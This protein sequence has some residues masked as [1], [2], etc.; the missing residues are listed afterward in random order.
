MRR[1]ALIPC[2]ALVVGCGDTTSTTD[3][4]PA[5][6]QARPP[7]DLGASPDLATAAD[8]T[9]AADLLPEADLG[10]GPDLTPLPDLAVPPDL[11]VADDLT[12]PSDLA[13]PLDLATPADF[14][15]PPDFAIPPDFATPPDLAIP[16][17]L[18][19]PAD[20]TP[21]RDLVPPPDLSPSCS[22]QIK[23]GRETDVDCGGPTC[24]RCGDGQACAAGT[25]CGS[26][27]CTANKCAGTTLLLLHFDGTNN[28]QTFVDSSG[29]RRPVTVKGD[30]KTST[31]DSKFGGAS[32]LFDGNGDFLTVPDSTDW[33]LGT[34][35]FTIEFWMRSN[36]NVQSARMHTF[37]FGNGS[38]T[39]IDFDYNDKDAPLNGWGYWVYWNSGGANRVTTN[40]VYTDD[41]WHH[42]VLVRAN[43]VFVTFVDGK[44]LGRVNYAAAVNLAGPNLGKVIG[45]YAGGT[46]YFYKGY[47]DELRILKGV[48]AWTQNFTPPSQAY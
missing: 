9:V 8:L 20:L 2:L 42:F 19:I 4:A 25:D 38:G 15:T 27:V 26:N 5:T 33:N 23:N 35:D 39:N 47:L 44:E 43:H 21:P 41:K 48:A 37:S 22:D 28:G 24:K 3:Q 11:A 13:A 40:T 7:A 32:G 1:F 34:G 29:Y 18:T 6:D 17:D 16:P 12:M 10:S 14:A 31:A 30:A 46:S 36:N 45:A